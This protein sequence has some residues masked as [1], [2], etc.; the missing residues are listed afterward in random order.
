[1]IKVRFF[2]IKLITFLFSFLAFV[3]IGKTAFCIDQ[4]PFLASEI[5]VEVSPNN[6]QPNETVT[7]YISSYSTD[8]NK[9]TITWRSEGGVVLSGIGKTSYSFSAPPANVSALYSISITPQGGKTIN[10]KISIRPADID[11]FWEADRGYAPP[12]YKGKT[13]PITNSSVKVV[14][15]PNT[16]NDR[17]F[18]FVWKKDGSVLNDKSGYD[19]NYYTFINSSFDLSNEITVIASAVQGDYVAQ[20][21][22][23][24]SVYEPKIIFYKKD[25]AMGIDYNNALI[26]NSSVTDEEITILAEPY[27]LPT[28]D[29][30]GKFIYDWSINNKLID[31]PLKK[32]ELSIRP[33]SRGGYAIINL[34]LYHISNMF[35][36]AFNSI[37]INF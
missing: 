22:I 17:G 24:I 9:A 11:L 18:S 2:K 13:L 37:K 28:K 27:Y 21:N 29:G 20:K 15:I 19:K 31:T 8:L 23:E 25:P 26:N 36:K 32:N 12:F 4:I 16:R 10:K 35:Q 1:M 7:I 33:T 5:I 3:L 6:P 14:A 34:D 30:S